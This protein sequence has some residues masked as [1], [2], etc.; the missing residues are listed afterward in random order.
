MKKT[1]TESSIDLANFDFEKEMASLGVATGPTSLTKTNSGLAGMPGVKSSKDAG[2]EGSSTNPFWVIVAMTILTVVISFL[3]IVDNIAYPFKIFVTFIHEISHSIATLITGGSVAS[4][5]LAVRWD[6]SGEVGHVGGWD[7]IIGSAG[8]VGSTIFG[9][10]LML[11]AKSRKLAKPALAVTGL[12]VLGFTLVY[13]AT[14]GT[15]IMGIASAA[16]LFAV[17]GL[18][19]KRMA[20]YFLTFL[21]VQSVLNAVYDLRVLF[22]A[23]NGPSDADILSGIYPVPAFLWSSTWLVISLGMLFL[24]MMNYYKMLKTT[25]QPKI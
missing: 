14:F 12:L 13:G 24:V 17:V 22:G 2:F 3:P 7:F 25:A 10:L 1:K 20:Y 15:Y 6:G 4:H 5:S 19:S 21:S 9:C 16:A 8:Y 11:L 23:H 18:A